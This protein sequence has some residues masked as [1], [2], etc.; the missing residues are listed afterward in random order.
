MDPIFEQ[1]VPSKWFHNSR[2]IIWNSREDPRPFWS[3]L[4]ELDEFVVGLKGLTTDLCDSFHVASCPDHP[5]QAILTIVFH[6]FFEDFGISQKYVRMR[7]ARSVTTNANASFR[8]VT[9]TF[10]HLSVS[11]PHDQNIPDTCRPAYFSNAVVTAGYNT[12]GLFYCMKIVI[13]VFESDNTPAYPQFVK[14]QIRRI[15][16]KVLERV[17]EWFGA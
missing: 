2:D 16:T 11:A 6:H 14:I 8:L 15:A 17:K 1:P 13:D 12:T 7:V 10:T 4:L 9:F 5:D 3:G